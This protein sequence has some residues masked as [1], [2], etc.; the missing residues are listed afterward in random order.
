M[1]RLLVPMVPTV[2]EIEALALGMSL[3]GS[4][5]ICNPAPTDTDED[6]I[7]LVADIHEFL[8]WADKKTTFETNTE[9]YDAD[10]RQLNFISFKRSEDRVNLIVTDLIGFYDKFVKAT[11]I[12][13][14]RNLLIKAERVKLFQ[15]ILYGN[16]TP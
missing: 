1:M 15:E 5:A 13:K 2:A 7:V 3:T 11:E 16:V 8:D 12:A 9:E 4:R 10:K 6:Y 14:E